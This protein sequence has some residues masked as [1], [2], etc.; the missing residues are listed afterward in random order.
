MASLRP[1]LI[2]NSAVA[3]ILAAASPSL[4]DQAGEFDYYLLALSWNSGWCAIEGA[5]KEAP[6]CVDEPKAGFT[7]HGLWPQ[8]KDGWPEFCSS[9]KPNPPRGV[10]RDQ[11][12]TFGSSGAAWHQ[13]NKHGRCSGLGYPEYY[14]L[15]EKLLNRYRAPEILMQIDEPLKVA[16]E[17]IEDAMRE[18]YPELTGDKMAVICRDGKFQ[19]LRI[20]LDKDFEPTSCLGRAARDCEY[21]PEVLPSFE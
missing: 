17:V 8:Y 2:R 4:A 20:C 12:E 5:R 21:A 7:L 15:S 14:T 18:T 10:T 19:E 3:C 9:S 1:L 6:Q 16:P 11:A 13:W